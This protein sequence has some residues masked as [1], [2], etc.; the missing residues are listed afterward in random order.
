MDDDHVIRASELGQYAYCAQAWWLGSVEGVPS[1]NVREMDAGTSAHER[2]GRNVQLSVWL[3]RA[4]MA[5]LVLGL[6]MLGLFLLAR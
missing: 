6:L 5:C 4:G 3:S 1:V 2:H